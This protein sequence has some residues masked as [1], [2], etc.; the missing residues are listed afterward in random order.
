LRRLIPACGKQSMKQVQKAI[1]KVLV[2]KPEI[3]ISGIGFE[4]LG[5]YGSSY[6]RLTTSEM[7]H[8]GF[9]SAEPSKR[10][11]KCRLTDAGIQALNT[12]GA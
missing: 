7:I 8:L 9:V 2:D 1:L 11:Y 3:S 6:T 5:S 4:L 10:G 12:A